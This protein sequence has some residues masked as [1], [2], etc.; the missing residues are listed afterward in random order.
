MEP[1]NGSAD[2]DM[3]K[4]KAKASYLCKDGSK[5]NFSGK[6]I[7]TFIDQY[8][9][10]KPQ[11]KLGRGAHGYVY[12]MKVKSDAGVFQNFAIKLLKLQIGGRRSTIEEK[13]AQQSEKDYLLDDPD[14]VKFYGAVQ[15]NNHMMLILELCVGAV[16]ALCAKLRQPEIYSK[17]NLTQYQRD[18]MI[19]PEVLTARVFACCVHGLVYLYGKNIYHSDVKPGN[20]L[21]TTKD[22][23]GGGHHFKLTDFSVA[24]SQTLAGLTGAT[25]VGNTRIYIT[26]ELATSPSASIS[27]A[28]D[29]WSLGITIAEVALG[30]HIIKRFLSDREKE[31]RDDYSGQPIQLI[32]VLDDLRRIAKE[33]EYK[34]PAYPMNAGYSTEFE[35]TYARL[36]EADPNKRY[37]Y[38]S[39]ESTNPE[40]I[41]KTRK[42]DPLASSYIGPDKGILEC[43]L[44]KQYNNAAFDDETNSNRVAFEEIMNLVRIQ[45]RRK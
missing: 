15:H 7:Y 40:Y 19:L 22:H 21:Y 26:P 44:F 2:N 24:A 10:K 23:E 41:D 32:Y 6:N 34:A 37:R 36:N 42:L 33:E 18:K 3:N 4:I 13:F 25:L 28:T 39:K 43:E 38:K 31:K 11:I 27:Q 9:S 30:Y 14:I 12:K 8:K 35:E 1:D 16:D 45:P 17:L 5:I 20:I 29:I